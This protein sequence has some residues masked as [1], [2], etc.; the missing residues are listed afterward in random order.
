MENKETIIEIRG[1]EE[2]ESKNGRKYA[3]FK[4]DKGTMT[5]FESNLINDLKKK[6]G[7]SVKVLVAE[8]NGF[9]NIREYVEDV[10]EITTEKISTG[11][12]ATENKFTE[13]RKSKDVSMNTSYAKDILIALIEKQKSEFDANALMETA[14]KMVKKARDAFDGE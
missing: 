5:C 3:S 6:V 2:K 11:N 7:K 12:E 9:T 13:A 8:V 1:V 10:G 14:I 4:T